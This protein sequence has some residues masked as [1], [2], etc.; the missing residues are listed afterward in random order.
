VAPGKKP[1]VEYGVMADADLLQVA[2]E[3]FGLAP[4]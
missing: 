2:N 1:R 4:K 3:Y